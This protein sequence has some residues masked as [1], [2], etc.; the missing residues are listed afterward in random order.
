MKAYPSLDDDGS[1]L[2]RIRAESDDG[3]V[4]G[5]LFH[6]IDPGDSWAGREWGEWLRAAESKDA[7]DMP[8]P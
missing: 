1:V 8:A 6:V 3:S 5:D 2:V 7:V 4:V